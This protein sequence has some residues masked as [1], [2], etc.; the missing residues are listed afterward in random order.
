MMVTVD[1][2]VVQFLYHIKMYILLQIN[3]YISGLTLYMIVR[4][5]AEGGEYEHNI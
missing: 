4:L 3:L 5:T 1:I 2:F